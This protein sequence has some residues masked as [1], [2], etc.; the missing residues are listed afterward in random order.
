MLT[1]SLVLAVDRRG[2]LHEPEASK[3]WLLVARDLM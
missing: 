2:I 3:D 1:L